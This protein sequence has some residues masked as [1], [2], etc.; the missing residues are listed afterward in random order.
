MIPNKNI[1]VS[2]KTPARNT[3]TGRRLKGVPNL[4]TGGVYS[5]YYGVDM[6]HEDTESD[7]ND[8]KESQTKREY[9]IM[10]TRAWRHILTTYFKMGTYGC[11]S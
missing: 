9:L 11:R 3:R 10:M 2:E 7:D 6:E 1:F 4:L 5:N 8:A